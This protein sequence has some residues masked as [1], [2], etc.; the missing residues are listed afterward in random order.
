MGL[1]KFLFGSKKEEIYN[2]RTDFNDL[3]NSPYYNYRQTE[4]YRLLKTEPLIDKIWGRGFDYPKYNDRFKTEEKLKLRELLLLVWWGKTKNGR[5]ISASIPKYFFIT[6]NLNAQKVTQLFRE[7]KWI[8]NEGDKVKLTNEGKL[9]YEKYCNLWEI[10]A[11]KGYPTNLDVDFP[12]WN[13]KQFEIMFYQK[14]LEY[15]NQHVEFCK[16]MLNYLEPLK[17]NTVNNGIRDD[18]NFYRSQLKSDLLCID[19]LKEKIKI[20]NELM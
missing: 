14:D 12:N 8:V 19:D 6:Y 2:R 11:F 3:I 16:R 13:Q 10:H 4:Y 17:H 5:K 15:Y 7:K 1:L 9:I 18:I 20:L